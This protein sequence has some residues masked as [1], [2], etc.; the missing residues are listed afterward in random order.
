M[1]KLIFDAGPLITSCKFNAASRLVIDYLLDYSEIVVAE[2]VRDEV[3]IA[4]ARYTD[5]QAAQQRL[6]Q[7]QI[8]ALAP[9]SAPDLEALLAPY[10]AST[11]EVNGAIDC[12]SIGAAD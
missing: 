3:V 9:P 8:V 11:K 10:G 12:H 7:G 2:S 1:G 5:A 6:E 4:G